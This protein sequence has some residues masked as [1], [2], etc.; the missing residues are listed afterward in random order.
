MS[1]AAT[2]GQHFDPRANGLNFIRLLLAAQVI[3]WHSF[4]VKGVEFES[5]FWR[6]LLASSGVDGFFAVS[7]FLILSSWVSNP[8]AR[9]YLAARVLRIFPAFL[10]ILVLTTVVA[11]P[12]ARALQ[13]ESPADVITNPDAYAYIWKNIGLWIFET[14]VAGT[15]SDVPYAGSWNA[16]LWT[17]S[18]EFACYLGVLI[19]GLL[20]LAS[21]RAVIVAGFLGALAVSLAVVVTGTG[22]HN[23][24]SLGRLTIMFAAGMV[25]F[26]FRDAIP[27]NRICVCGAAAAIFLGLF[28]PDYRL[29]A[30]LPFAYLLMVAG[31]ALRHPAFRFRTD[32]SYG[33]YIYAFPVQQL[34]VIAGAGNLAIAP[35][36]GLALACTL[37]LAWLSWTLIEKPALGLKD[38]LGGTR[39]RRTVQTITTGT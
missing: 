34:L 21:R 37:P 20:G 8:N 1:G 36:A 2:L 9:R 33:V 30:A 3:L 29:V 15:P 5:A 18:W 35:F 10:V 31:G 4:A 14:G 38:R 7:G 27:V 25:L 16:S 13:G 12:L 26:T 24:E 28:L 19:L 6:P 17:L 23:L 39:G 32:V 22:S 11:A